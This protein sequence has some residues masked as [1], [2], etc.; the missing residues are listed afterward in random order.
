MF[1]ILLKKFFCAG[2]LL[3]VFFSAQSQ[4]ITGKITDNKQQPVSDA[5][6]HLL[7]TNTATFTDAQ[8]NFTF[9]NISPGKYIIAISALGYAGT[10]EAIAVGNTNAELV[11][12]LA[13]ATAQLDAV[14]VTMPRIEATLRSSPELLKAKLGATAVRSLVFQ[15]LNCCICFADIE[16]M[17]MATSCSASSFFWAVT[18][19][20]SSCA[21]ASASLIIN[22]ALL[23]PTVIASVVPA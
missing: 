14:I 20:A 10:T 16:L 19:T 6:I 1:Q 12:K 23:L 4:T 18:I 22:S 15:S 9:K 7:N 21:V 5:F 17:L 13:D 3:T 11:I 2:L 8:G